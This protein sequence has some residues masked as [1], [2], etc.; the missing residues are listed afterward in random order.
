MARELGAGAW[1]YFGDPRAIHHDGRTFTGW[2]STTGNVWVAS[3]APGRQPRTNLIYRGL[4]RDDHN[5][6]S[7]VFRPDGHLVVFFSPH[8]GHH[9]PKDQVSR[10]RY[11]I[12]LHPYSI[13]EFGPVHTVDTNVPGGLGYTYPNPI[14]QRGKL[15]LFWRG[16]NWNPTFS[17]TQNGRDWVPARELVYHGGGA[18]PYAKYVGDGRYRIHGIF[19]DGHPHNV[20]NSLHYLRYENSGLYAASGR[21]LGTLRQVPLHTSR[22]DH[23]YRYSSRGG[24][25]WPHDIALDTNGRP[26]VVYTRRIGGD[27]TFWYAYHNG[28]K[29]VSRKIVDAGRGYVTFN[30]GG[31]SFDHEDTRFIYLSRTVGQWNQVEQWFTPD[32]GRTWTS[33]PLTADP[34]GFSMRPVTPRRMRSGNQVLYVWG[35]RRTTSFT[36]YVTRIHVLDF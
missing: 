32:H 28:K 35:D 18:R 14:Q 3:H 34:S 19:S 27:D 33:R 36:K 24:R 7:L 5:N 8:S 30:S 13:S 21:K 15:W 2:I 12:G 31:A 6:P 11:R 16:G 25:A 23:I 1:S 17:Y 26:R 9:L 4:G 20:N 10:M 29:W 22:L